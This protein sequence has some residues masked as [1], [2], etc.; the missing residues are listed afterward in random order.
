MNFLNYFSRDQ[1][2]VNDYF[3]LRRERRYAQ[4]GPKAKAIGFHNVMHHVMLPGLVL[5]RR[6]EGRKL[7]ILADRRTA[8]NAKTPTVYVCAHIGG[9]DIE[10]AFEAIGDPCHLLL[11]DPG[12]A[13][14][15]FD[16]LILGLNG[17]ICLET[18]DKTDRHIAKE[19]S[20]ALLKKGGSLLVFPE[21]AWN[22]TE[23]EPVMKL[24]PGAAVFALET[25]ADIVPMALERYGDH[26]YA[27]IGAEIHHADM[28][29]KDTKTVT[30]E[31][32]DTL[33]TLKWEI[34]EHMG[35]HS[36]GEFS[37]EYTETEFHPM[38]AMVSDYTMQDAIKT[39]YREKNITTPADAFAHLQTRIPRRENAFIFRKN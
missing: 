3:R 32:R 12:Q 9:Q 10:T 27:N 18:Q 30:A 29:D 35:F 7:T 1:Q 37:S 2:V 21:G 28:N 8:R 23:N 20:I 34:W 31:L 15:N 33:A 11:G 39:R 16:G 24:F 14:R 4:Y 5:L 26:Y 6:L 25:G 36:R 22:I 13:Y 17:V 38:F 19:Q